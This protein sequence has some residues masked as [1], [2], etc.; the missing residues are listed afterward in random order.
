MVSEIDQLCSAGRVAEPEAYGSWFRA[1]VSE[2]IDDTRPTIP[3]H[4][5]MD[6]VQTIIDRKRTLA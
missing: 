1:K 3:H 6:E 2:A 5:V 4:Q